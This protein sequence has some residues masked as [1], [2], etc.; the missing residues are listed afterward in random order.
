M[1]KEWKHDY[2][3]GVRLRKKQLVCTFITLCVCHQGLNGW[4]WENNKNLS[5]ATEKNPGFFFKSDQSVII[6][7][8]TKFCFK[9]GVILSLSITFSPLSVQFGI[10]K[11]ISK[12]RV[13]R[14]GFFKRQSELSQGFQNFLPRATSQ[15][16]FLGC[17]CVESHPNLFWFPWNAVFQK[18]YCSPSKQFSI[19]PFPSPWAAQFSPSMPHMP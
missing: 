11:C 19:Y 2:S 1:K 12:Q 7:L 17:K 16:F 14:L 15:V 5:S 4:S 8:Q 6:Q 18:T 9:F 10:E 3:L 13:N